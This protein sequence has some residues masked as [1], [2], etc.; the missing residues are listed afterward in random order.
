MDIIKDQAEKF[1]D[2]SLF[3][4]IK[5]NTLENLRDKI[6]S[7]LYNFNRQRDK[8]KYLQTL[9]P[10]IINE[11]LKHEET[12]SKANCDYSTERDIAI[13]VI[14]QDI[15]EITES[16][17]YKSPNNFSSE[18]ESILMSRLT[19]IDENLRKLG[20]GQE[21]LFEEIEELKLHFEIG[22]KNW[23]QLVKG[24]LFDLG[25]KKTLEETIIKQTWDALKEGF[26]NIPNL[27]E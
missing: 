14:D 10:L 20:Y 5:H 17:S 18:E 9:K 23:F 2:R 11:K 8:L 6:S 26:D 24:K 4:G 1:F 22:K 7:E 3:G 15:E 12:C 21:I 25:L 19:V 13:F 16:Y 27:L